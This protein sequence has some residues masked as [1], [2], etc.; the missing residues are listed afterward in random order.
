[1]AHG[2]DVQNLMTTAEYD[3]TTDSFVMNT[4]SVEATKWWIGDLG[5]YATHAC[6]FA[7][8]IINGKKYGINA[9]IVPLR[10]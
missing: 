10:D 5:V 2:S 1:M 7:Q 6:V 4:P 9:F 3:I 8:L